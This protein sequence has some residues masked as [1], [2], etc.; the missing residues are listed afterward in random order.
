MFRKRMSLERDRRDFCRLV[1][2][3]GDGILFK[4][5][6]GGKELDLFSW[7]SVNAKTSIY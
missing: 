1:G 2:W 3:F 7:D 4:S 6:R 5:P